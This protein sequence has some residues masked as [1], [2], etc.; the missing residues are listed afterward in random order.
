MRL[1]TKNW[2]VL[3][4]AVGREATKSQ[5]GFLSL[6]FFVSC[7]LPSLRVCAV[8]CCVL[9]SKEFVVKNSIFGLVSGRS[10]EVI[11]RSHFIRHSKL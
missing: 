11:G 3:P 1:L 4:Q 9:S 2:R 6:S 5:T 10:Q 7:F 8:L